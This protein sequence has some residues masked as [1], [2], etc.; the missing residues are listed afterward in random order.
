MSDN[1][2]DW[3]VSDEVSVALQRRVLG[4]EHVEVATTLQNVAAV[5]KHTDTAASW[6]KY[7]V[8]REGR[9]GGRDGGT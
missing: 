5:L 2:S 1:I 7:E 8:Q 9:D 6:D 3:H 4:G